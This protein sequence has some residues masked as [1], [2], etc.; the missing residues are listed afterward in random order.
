MLEPTRCHGR[1]RGHALKNL[2]W[3]SPGGCSTGTKIISENTGVALRFALKILRELA[4]GGVIQ[5][6][7]GVLGGY[8]L[9][10]EPENIRHLKDDGRCCSRADTAAGGCQTGVAI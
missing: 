8:E 5:S 1:C 4:T 10:R 9:A 7:K 6:H 2:T 3:S